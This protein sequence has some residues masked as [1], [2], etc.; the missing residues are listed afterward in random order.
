MQRPRDQAHDGSC[1]YTMLWLCVN[2]DQ[3][4]NRN[5]AVHADIET[6]QKLVAK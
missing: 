4:V 2:S 6:R 1:G 5:F 3:N